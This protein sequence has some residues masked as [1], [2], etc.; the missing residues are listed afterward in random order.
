MK[1]I[2]FE[3]DEHCGLTNKLFNLIYLIKICLNYN[4]TIIEP[5]FGWKKK[6][7]FSEIYD[8]DFLNNGFKKIYGRKLIHKIS[9][10]KNITSISIKDLY[11]FKKH[12]RTSKTIL[13][14]KKFNNKYILYIKFFRTIDYESNFISKIR[15]SMKLY[16]T[17]PYLIV[18]TNLKL[19][20]KLLKI[21]EKYNK[22]NTTSIHIRLESDLVK[23]F[24]ER[25]NRNNWHLKEKEYFIGIN[26]II[27][28]MNK[29]KFTNNVFFTTGENQEEFKNTFIKNNY[30]AEYFFDNTLEYEQNAAINFNICLSSK[31]FIGTCMSTY[32][33][34]ITTVRSIKNI[35]NSYLYNT[36]NIMERTD[37][38][39]HCNKN[40]CITKKLII[41]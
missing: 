3:L 40:N 23:W 39:I 13:N 26:D 7:L 21:S 34:A 11:N 33:N 18:F 38:G 27:N 28:K 6:I 19:N 1:Y 8:I 37:Y 9:D 29:N 5:F 22:Y 4:F 36:I 41:L 10:I 15:T 25:R 20:K 14:I 17:E 30:N 31:Y 16:R 12:I 35:N 32:S 2:E 24:N